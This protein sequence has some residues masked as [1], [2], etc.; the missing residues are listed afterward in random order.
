MR[1]AVLDETRSPWLLKHAVFVAFRNVSLRFFQ[2]LCCDALHPIVHLPGDNIFCYGTVCIRMHFIVA[3]DASYF[4]YGAI[5]Q[6]MVQRGQRKGQQLQQ[7]SSHLKDRYKQ[8]RS[9]FISEGDSLC[10][11]TLWVR[12]AHRGDLDAISQVSLLSLDTKS[13]ADLV[14]SYPAVQISMQKHALRFF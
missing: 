11:P 8:S 14:D 6:G 2:R 5:L 3:G 4:K 7:G 9:G 1:R 13:L 12:W 10:E